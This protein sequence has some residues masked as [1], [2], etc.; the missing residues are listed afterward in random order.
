MTFNAACTY[1]LPPL[2]SAVPCIV[3]STLD[4]PVGSALGDTHRTP[5][6]PCA[7]A[8]DDASITPPNRHR[9]A[10]ASAACASREPAIV[11]TVPPSAGP[12]HGARPCTTSDTSSKCT[13]LDVY[14]RPFVLT[15]TTAWPADD[16][17]LLHAT[18]DSLTYAAATDVALK[19][20]RSEPDASAADE[21]PLPS[22]VTGVPP[23]AAPLG[24]HTDDTAADGRYVKKMPSLCANC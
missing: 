16:A 14:S 3:S 12:D 4:H 20:H 2:R 19:R 6:E 15:S 9:S 7:D 13:P 1:T 10:S 21:K 17:V 23:S 5:S 22:T 24:G 11:T 18:T 8:T